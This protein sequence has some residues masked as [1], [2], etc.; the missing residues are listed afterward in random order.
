MKELMSSNIYEFP[1]TFVVCG[2]CF[3][4]MDKEAFDKLQNISKNIFFVCLENVHMNMVAHKIASIL[5]IGKT[6]KLIFASVDRSPHCIQLH[7]MRTELEKIMNLKEI[8]IINY[9]SNKGD[10]AEISPETIS[11]SKNLIQLS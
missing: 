3:Q 5:R 4:N 9:V 7:Y 1:E 8:E 10:L 11:K 6:K 2:S